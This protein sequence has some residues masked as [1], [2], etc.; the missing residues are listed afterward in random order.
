M[1]VP[2]LVFGARLKDVRQFLFL[3]REREISKNANQREGDYRANPKNAP[4]SGKG[5]AEN[6]GNGA[7]DHHYPDTEE[8]SQGLAI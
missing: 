7:S 4:I 3:E 8:A 1:L 5:L 2:A 6:S